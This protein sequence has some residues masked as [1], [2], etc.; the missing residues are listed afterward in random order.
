MT[1]ATAQY[2]T[3]VM[4]DGY[5]NYVIRLAGYAVVGTDTDQTPTLLAQVSALNPPCQVLRIDRVKYSMPSGSIFDLQLWWQNT[6]PANDI[7]A[8]S[9]S[10]GDQ[11]DFWNTG[12][13]INNLTAG[14]TG[15]LMWG[16]SGL[17]VDLP[18]PGNSAMTNIAAGAELSFAIIVECVKLQPQ[19][20]L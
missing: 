15:N 9:S 14:F 1:I 2:S 8:W 11:G 4:R 13:I 5:R 17:S 3:Q 16:T 12:G 19:Y 6:T 20:P 18:T 10:G 7:L